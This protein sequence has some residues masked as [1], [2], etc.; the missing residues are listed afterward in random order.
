MKVISLELVLKL[1]LITAAANKVHIR[2][3]GW[4]TS[5]KREIKQR[6]LTLPEYVRTLPPIKLTRPKP[7]AITRH[8]RGHDAR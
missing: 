5:S 8:P 1:S 2:N 6:L 4:G 3:I 7:K